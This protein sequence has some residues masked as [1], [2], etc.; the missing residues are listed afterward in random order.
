M[1]LYTKHGFFSVV[2]HR[3]DPDFVLIRARVKAHMVSLGN[4]C[5]YSLTVECTPDADYAYRATV[6]RTQW[7]AM[8]NT[9]TESDELCYEN[10]KD[11]CAKTG[12]DRAYLG[13]LH[14][15]WDWTRRLRTQT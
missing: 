2:Q 3:D 9:L 12:R 1:W 5:D 13:V 7:Q 15:V 14:D 8:L 4:A 6:R 10:F 11:E